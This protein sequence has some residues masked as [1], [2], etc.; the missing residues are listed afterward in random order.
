MAHPSDY[1]T[2]PRSQDLRQTMVD[3]QL[4]TFDVTDA[5]V[6]SAVLAVPREPFVSGHVDSLVYSDAHLIVRGGQT[7][8][9]LL[10]PMFLA[11]ALQLAHVTPRDRVLDVGGAGGYGAALASR[12]AHEAIALDDDR[13][14]V[15]QADF[16][17]RGLGLTNARAAYGDLAA[18]LLGEGPFD[19]ILIGGAVEE[20]PEALLAQ[21]ADG[22]RLLAVRNGDSSGQMTLW[23]RSGAAI[24]SRPL[25]A[26]PADVLPAFRRKPSFAF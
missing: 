21:L 26:A 19:V 15:D 12:L 9:R 22:G 20:E 3:R 7:R 23:E 4:R 18:G 17:F 1:M 16:A 6:L 11:R 14:F 13:G 5:D 8:R 24:G 25:F 10:A 2:S